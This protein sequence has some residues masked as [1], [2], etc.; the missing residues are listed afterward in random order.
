VGGL[1]KIHLIL[2]TSKGLRVG[3]P[4]GS[5]G[6]EYACQSRR[7]GFYPWIEKIP[8]RK[9]WQPTPIFLPGQSQWTEEPGR[10]HTVQGCLESDKTEQLTHKRLR[11]REKDL[12]RF[13]IS[14]INPGE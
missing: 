5:D 9:K 8:W 4:G 6:K 3:F 13:L 14:I 10:L 12:H 11:V 7:P 2:T 1:F